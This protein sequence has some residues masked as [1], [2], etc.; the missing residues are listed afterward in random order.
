MFTEMCNNLWEEMAKKSHTQRAQLAH[1]E[2]RID[3]KP[4]SSGINP[5][6]F[7]GNPATDAITWL[8]SFARIANINNWSKDNQLNAFPLY[9]SGV[10]HTWFL[11]LSDKV[12]SDF[13]QLKA[14][15]QERFASGPQDWILSQ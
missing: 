15:F 14:A 7:D 3:K 12:K 5:D 2:T 11:S 4:S 1:I 9:L 10:A 13:G 6:V 8:D